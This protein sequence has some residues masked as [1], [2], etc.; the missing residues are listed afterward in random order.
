MKSYNLYLFL[1]LLNLNQ[2]AKRKVQDYNDIRTVPKEENIR[3][4]MSVKEHM[5]VK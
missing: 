4:W 5:V 2:S 1:L 3:C